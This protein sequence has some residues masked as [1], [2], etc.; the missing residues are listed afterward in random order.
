M[1]A[2]TILALR[3]RFG[4]S[5]RAF[6]RPLGVAQSTGSRYETGERPLPAPVAQLLLIAYGGRG[7]FSRTLTRLRP[8]LEKYFTQELKT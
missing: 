6:W 8:Y 1:K 3:R 4:L 7:Q 2:K 5:Q